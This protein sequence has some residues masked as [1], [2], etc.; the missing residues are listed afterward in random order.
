MERRPLT[1]RAPPHRHDVD[2]AHFR[3]D[4]DT[5]RSPGCGGV[6]R[7]TPQWIPNVHL[8]HHF[9]QAHMV[10]GS[11]PGAISGRS[12]GRVPAEPARSAL[13]VDDLRLQSP[14]AHRSVAEHAIDEQR[15]RMR[16]PA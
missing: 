13:G 5:P 9:V 14:T 10:V 1:A 4:A 16:P 2:Q 15:N 6:D 3:I 7:G 12:I 8:L 11:L